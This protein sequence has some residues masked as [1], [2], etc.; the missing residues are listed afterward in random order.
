MPSGTPPVDGVE[1]PET[2]G[3][4]RVGFPRIGALAGCAL[5]AVFILAAAVGPALVPYDPLSPDPPH[6]LMGPDAAHW[7]GTDQY[8]RDVFSRVVVAARLDLGIALAAVVASLLIGSA[9]GAA[10]GW[11]GRWVDRLV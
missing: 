2:R 7:F 11:A 9:L 4:R 3:H 1:G 5:L 8:G 10:A 6:R